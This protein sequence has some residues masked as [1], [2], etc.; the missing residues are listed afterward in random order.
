MVDLFAY[1]SFF[2]AHRFLRAVAYREF[3]RFVHGK[4]GTKR[5]PLPAC[6]YHAIRSKFLEDN[7]VGFEDE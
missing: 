7:L 2:P 5:L 1:T 6:A 3:T 4:L